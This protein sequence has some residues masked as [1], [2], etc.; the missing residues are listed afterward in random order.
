MLWSTDIRLTPDYVNG[1]TG[2]DNGG[3]LYHAFRNRYFSDDLVT[4]FVFKI[5][6]LV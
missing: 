1:L 5:H 4:G 3:D 6:A 2:V